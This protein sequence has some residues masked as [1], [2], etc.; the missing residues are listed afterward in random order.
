MIR[1][2]C[3]GCGHVLTLPDSIPE[4]GAFVC[5]H[6]G[7]ELLN[8]EVAR[9]FRWKAVDPYVRRH[10]ASR[11]NLW[12][13]LGGAALWLPILAALQLYR[14]QFDA[15]FFGLVALPYLGL[16]VFLGMRRARTPA[17]VWLYWLWMGLGAYL[18]Y[19]GALLFVRPAWAEQLAGVPPLVTSGGQLFSMGGIAFVVG[20]FGMVLQRRRAS[21]LPRISG[22]PPEA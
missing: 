16:L 7:L 6:C 3:L 13:G 19:L 10:G 9:K 14:G 17:M 22:T 15:L 4:G 1:I 12:G 5:A 18:L 11:A 8:V 2:E 21:R 20:G